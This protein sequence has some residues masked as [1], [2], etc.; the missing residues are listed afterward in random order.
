MAKGLHDLLSNRH[1]FASQNENLQ[2]K[3]Q[4][5]TSVPSKDLKELEVNVKSVLIA[6]GKSLRV[7]ELEEEYKVF[8]RSGIPFR[9]FGTF[10]TLE[11]LKRIPEACEISNESSNDPLVT[12]KS[13]RKSAHI[14]N[15]VKKNKTKPKTLPVKSVPQKDVFVPFTVQDEIR[16]ILYLKRR[17]GKEEIMKLLW[18]KFDLNYLNLKGSIDELIRSLPHLL[19]NDGAFVRSAHQIKKEEVELPE[20]LCIEG[21]H[22][23]PSFRLGYRESQISQNLCALLADKKQIYVI[24]IPRLY[25]KKFGKELKWQQFGFADL[26]RFLLLLPGDFFMFQSDSGYVVTE[27]A[28]PGTVDCRQ[29]QEQHLCGDVVYEE[30]LEK[31]RKLVLHVNTGLNSK[32]LMSAYETLYFEKLLIRTNFNQF[33]SELHNKL[34]FK[35]KEIG[36]SCVLFPCNMYDIFRLKEKKPEKL[37]KVHLPIDVLKPG[38]SLKSVSFAKV[39][40]ANNQQFCAAFVS[41]VES[42]NNFYIRVAGMSEG[43]ME[44]DE[45][46]RVLTGDMSKLY[47]LC[48]EEYDIPV[49]EFKVK[50]VCAACVKGE[51]QRVVILDVLDNTRML[52]KSVDY[53]TYHKVTMNSLKYLPRRFSN[54]PRLAYPATLFNIKPMGSEWDYEAIL[55]FRKLTVGN[56]MDP[57]P[58]S[59][60]IIHRSEEGVLQVVLSDEHQDKVIHLGDELVDWGYASFRFEDEIFGAMYC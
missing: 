33:L 38:D 34:I 44:L 52:V 25:L 39:I 14:I 56:N 19:I 6:A 2:R 20:E 57:K 50:M 10:S 43:E 1:K 11:L 37:E 12:V 48:S 36:N 23:C 41:F 15:L 58:L 24:D 17:V 30:I 45:E 55:T 5:R 13:S 54:L 4:E 35:I 22:L 59:A 26:W 7:S 29:F 28:V 31:I 18:E 42:P 32:H 8:F 27:N 3:I 46:F 9:D 53:G 60:I 40:N 16:H 47:S 49:S 21:A 51:W